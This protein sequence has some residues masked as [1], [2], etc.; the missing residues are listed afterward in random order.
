M[1]RHTHPG[2]LAPGA[3]VLA[4]VVTERLREAGEDFG[5]RFEHGLELRLVDLANV[6]A[7]MRDRFLEALLHLA[8]MVTRIALGTACHGTSPFHDHATPRAEGPASGRRSNRL[9]VSGV[10]VKR[11]RRSLHAAR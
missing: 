11:G 8:R 5:R 10:P 3:F 9:G 6:F 4:L 7:Q 2:R 1:T